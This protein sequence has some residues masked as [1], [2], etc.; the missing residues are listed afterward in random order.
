MSNSTSYGN[1]NNWTADLVHIKR[2]GY[3]LHQ[4]VRVKG[5]KVCA[6]QSMSNHLPAGSR[7]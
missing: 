1:L 7:Q 2:A 6:Q 4:L 5:V 3:P